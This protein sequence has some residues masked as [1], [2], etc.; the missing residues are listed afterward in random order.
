MVH[1]HLG[2]LYFESRRCERVWAV[3]LDD[4]KILATNMFS[5]LMTNGA[6]IAVVIP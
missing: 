2:Y 3:L 5:E 6:N 4:R 1:E